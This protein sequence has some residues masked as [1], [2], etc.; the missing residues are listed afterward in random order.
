MLNSGPRSEK[1]AL[2]KYTVRA[3]G[4]ES[5]CTSQRAFPETVGI[6]SEGIAVFH[7]SLSEHQVDNT[8]AEAQNFALGGQ[9]YEPEGSLAAV[10]RRVQR[11]QRIL[12][13]S[14]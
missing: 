2:P 10:S 3:L 13:A 1:R 6:H 14:M 11:P 5:Q 9:I 7:F 4:G 8:R 12:L